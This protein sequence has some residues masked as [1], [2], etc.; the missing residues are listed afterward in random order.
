MNYIN[1]LSVAIK[2]AVDAGEAV[3]EVYESDFHV[4]Y[5]EDQSPLTLADQKAHDIISTQLAGFK[6]PLLSEEG[7]TLPYAQRRD[8]D[9]LWIV[10]PLDGTKEFVKRNGEFTVNIALV[11]AG[12]PI[13]GVVFAPVREVLY[14]ALQGLGA[15]KLDRMDAV[16]ALCERISRGECTSHDLVQHGQSLPLEQPE[17]SPYT[18]VGSRSHATEALENFVDQKRREFGTI[19]FIPAGSSLK[20]CLVAEGRAHIYPRLAPTM[21]WDTA[22]GHAV[23]TCAGA[24]IYS[25]NSGEP[26]LYN[27]QDLLNPWFIVER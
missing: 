23:V 3:L 14:F 11:N 6:I 2:A 24:H 25:H 26:L 5:K 22:A 1:H 7:K 27:K 10:D 9:T 17:D 15:Y 12:Q 4:D 18:I 21:E 16:T 13:L 8:W 19:D 20:L